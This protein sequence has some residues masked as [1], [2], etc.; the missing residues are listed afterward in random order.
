MSATDELLRN[1]SD[2]DVGSPR[3]RP[4]SSGST[5]RNAVHP[6]AAVVSAPPPLAFVDQPPRESR[7]ARDDD[8]D[9]ALD[10]A[11]TREMLDMETAA[12]NKVPEE[13]TVPIVPP[14]KERIVSSSTVRIVVIW[15]L[16]LLIVDGVGVLLWRL[17]GEDE[18]AV[19][20]AGTLLI[21]WC[22]YLTAAI[23]GWY[24]IGILVGLIFLVARKSR[25]LSWFWYIFYPFQKLIVFIL[26]IVLLL[27]TWES[28]LVDLEEDVGDYVRSFYIAIASC[29]GVLA[30]A[31]ALL[32]I[33]E[34]LL[35]EEIA[36]TITDTT[37]WDKIYAEAFEHALGNV[38]II[39]RKL[40]Q[41][42][43]FV[44]ILDE[45][46][47]GV[48][49]KL[50]LVTLAEGLREDGLH[51][52]SPRLPYGMLDVVQDDVY[53]RKESRIA[54]TNLF[55]AILAHKSGAN[56]SSGTAAEPTSVLAADQVKLTN[57]GTQVVTE[58]D[59]IAYTEYDAREGAKLFATLNVRD[60]DEVDLKDC[61]EAT[62]ELFIARRSLVN[63][64]HGRQVLLHVSKS[65]I[66]VAVLFLFALFI[67]AVFGIE[68]VPLLVPIA[69]LFLAASFAFSR[70]LSNFVTSLHLIFFTRPY[71]LG[72]AVTI[73]D[74]DTMIVHRVTIMTS[75]L[76]D[77]DG[78]R[79]I[80]AN[81]KIANSKITN[82]RR[83][84]GIWQTQRFVMADVDMTSETLV[85][86]RTRF[87]EWI[88][89][90]PAL[91][92]QKFGIVLVH[93]SSDYKVTLQVRF[94]LH[95]RW[96][97]KPVWVSASN[98][99]YLFLLETFKDLNLHWGA[100]TK[101]YKIKGD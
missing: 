7:G 37:F 73:N 22:L 15:I 40:I 23:L 65:L 71:E 41:T 49:T 64:I 97:D 67:L 57:P 95:A 12:R 89:A 48:I 28:V 76:V 58:N 56:G 88:A 54:S 78:R 59:C 86:L 69:S 32:M 11:T 60:R 63:T 33:I 2:S 13:P 39:R 42:S 6:T 16:L 24:V 84:G 46:T 100:D 36:M 14:K 21:L 26:W 83:T 17:Y 34:I 3:E 35:Y 101:V 10:D 75:E 8:G 96:Q 92:T 52:L 53:L 44:D 18:D 72:D 80:L 93:C 68:L 99:V 27:F 62:W 38:R 31:K 43:M 79:H 5:S 47:L 29:A 20:I 85:V 74:D 90:Q 61:D 51:G 9:G 87:R 70:F 4:V 1:M 25:L 77:L 30:G 45:G 91:F 66:D 50:K 55:R 81:H 94:Q 82:L 98:A 19:R